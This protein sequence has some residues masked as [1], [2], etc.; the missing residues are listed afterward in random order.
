MSTPSEPG[1]PPV[2]ERSGPLRL[3]YLGL[4]FLFVGLGALGVILPGLP[5]TPFMLLA[6]WMFS[7]SSARFHH[8]LW[9]HRVFGPY[10]RNWSRHRVIPA[11]AK[12]I[13]LLF[14]SLGLTILVVRQS[15]YAIVLTTAAVCIWGAVFILR[16]PSRV[17]VRTN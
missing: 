7:K 15:H 1:P 14:M 8:W 5:T 17:P 9:T 6:A 13:S 4:G 3:V 2:T 11:H 12:V 16:C 10:V